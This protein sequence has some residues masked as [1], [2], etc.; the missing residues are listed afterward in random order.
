MENGAYSF[1]S[2]LFYKDLYANFERVGDYVMKVNEV[3]AE[4]D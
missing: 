1:K 2:G 4:R 3:I